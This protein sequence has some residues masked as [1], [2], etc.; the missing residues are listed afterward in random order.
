MD[1]PRDHDVVAHRRE[2]EP[3][4]LAP[5]GQ[6]RDVLRIGRAAAC[7]YSEAVFDDNLPNVQAARGRECVRPG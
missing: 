4:L 6:G 7:W 2:A 3:Q 1:G 5:A